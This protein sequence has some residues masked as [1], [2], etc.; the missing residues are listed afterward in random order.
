MADLG[1]EPSTIAWN[2]IFT[3]FVTLNFTHSQEARNKALSILRVIAM[4]LGKTP[5][6]P[7]LG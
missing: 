3:K 6:Q 5:L 4:K 1:F 7:K 2:K